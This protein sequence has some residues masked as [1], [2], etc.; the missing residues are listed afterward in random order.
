MIIKRA[1]IIKKAIMKVHIKLM[2]RNQLS[3]NL[4]NYHIP[5]I[6]IVIMIHTLLIISQ[7]LINQLNIFLP[8]FIN[9]KS[10]GNLTILNQ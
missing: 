5:K 10:Q 2:I 3:M 8:L 4:M 6:P 9:Q 1:M 7:N